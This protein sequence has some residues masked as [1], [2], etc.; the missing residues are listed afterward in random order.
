MGRQKKEREGKGERDTDQLVI[1]SPEVQKTT[2]EADK[3]RGVLKGE[4]WERVDGCATGCGERVDTRD[5][6]KKTRKGR[7]VEITHMA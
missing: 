2:C 1:Q 6:Q 5:E 3:T 7:G 4:Q